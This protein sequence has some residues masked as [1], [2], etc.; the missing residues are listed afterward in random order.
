MSPKKETQLF[1]WVGAA[2]VLLSSV[3]WTA[4]VATETE[5]RLDTQDQRL[6]KLTSI[7]ERQIHN[8]TVILEWI[9][10]HQDIHT[11]KDDK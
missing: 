5:F 3:W 1:R 2:M 7:Q 4:T 9:K 8:V 6:E 10:H 11:L